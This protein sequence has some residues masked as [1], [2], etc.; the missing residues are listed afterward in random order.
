MLNQLPEELSFINEYRHANVEVVGANWLISGFDENV[1]NCRFGDSVITIEFSIT[2]LDGSLLTHRSNARLLDAIKHYICA[3]THPN[4]IGVAVL[5]AATGKSY[6]ARALHVVDHFLLRGSF[7]GA[8]EA[9]FRKLSKND[10]HDFLDTVSS[11]RAIKISIYE[12]EKRIFEFVRLLKVPVEDL[13][14]ARKRLPAIFETKSLELPK[15]L[16]EEQVQIARLWLYRNGFYYGGGGDDVFKKQLSFSRLLAHIIG[17]RVLGN[18]KFPNLELDYLSFE[19]RERFIREL[20]AVKVQSGGED[21]RAGAELVQ[22][23]MQALSVMEVGVTPAASLASEGALMA[24]DDKEGLKNG[25]LKQKGRFTTLPF[26]VANQSFK[27][28]IEFYLEYGHDLVTYYLRL[29]EMDWQENVLPDVPLSLKR[30]GIRKF[31]NTEK[32]A[33]DFFAELRSG[34]SLY[35][36]LQVLL[37]A[38]TILVNTLMARR[39]SELLG[40][41]SESIVKDGEY[42]FLKFDL[43]KANIGEIRKRVL[44]PLPE[45]GAEA[46]GLLAELSE[47]LSD[48]GYESPHTLLQR[49]KF[50]HNPDITPYGT[51]KG[52]IHWMLLCLDRFCDYFEITTDSDGARYYIRTHQL[53]RN[54]AMLFF[55]RGSFGGIEVLRYF[56][57]HQ[58]PSLT[59]RYVTEPMAGGVLRHVK[60]KVATELIK[61]DSAATESLAAFICQ[62]YG[63]TLDDLHVLPEAD[64]CAYIE[65][66]LKTNEAEI[67]PEF[68]EGPNGEEY[69][70]VYKVFAPRTAT[71]GMNA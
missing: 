5:S 20:M 9:E 48:L 12:P 4:V 41:T 11:G 68:I 17:K 22:S 66:L 43:G 28:A 35:Q 44:R 52:G 60:A 65:D 50:G 37:G 40:L 3:Q 29:A 46:L 1:W 13:D 59:Y 32:S 7:I 23:Y 53:R 62:R 69:K 15:G 34:T 70:I 38:I 58:K 56:L 21:E 10:I 27:H 31:E 6:L 24:I 63:V 64:V 30:L 54:F 39:A 19:P 47:R 45:L 67:E 49:F 42:F 18:L 33:K 26:E 55:W 36:M 14:A 71:G 8:R 25:L 16:S 2:L 61:A 57:G 51:T